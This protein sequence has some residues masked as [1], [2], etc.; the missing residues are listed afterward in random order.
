MPTKLIKRSEFLAANLLELSLLGRFYGISAMGNPKMHINWVDAL[1]QYL[2]DDLI[3]FDWDVAPTRGSKLIL[4]DDIHYLLT[5]LSD[6]KPS[7]V[8]LANMYKLSVIR[9]NVEKYSFTEN[10][11]I[12][13][14]QMLVKLQLHDGLRLLLT[15]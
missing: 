3:L 7:T 8:M 1:I 5:I 2:P 13:L 9:D 6:A 12:F 4:G 14:K 15:L 10:H 11:S